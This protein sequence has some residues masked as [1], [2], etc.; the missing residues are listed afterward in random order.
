MEMEIRDIY[1]YIYVCI[2]Y[3]MV[4]S[5]HARLQITF[6]TNSTLHT[7]RVAL[8]NTADNTH[9]RRKGN[10]LKRRRKQEREARQNESERKVGGKDNL[11]L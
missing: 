4:C 10:E 11:K 7:S 8:T 1:F 9:R 5:S 6:A 2:V 3:S